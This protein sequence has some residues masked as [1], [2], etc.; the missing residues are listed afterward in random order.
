MA[1]AVQQRAAEAADVAGGV[2]KDARLAAKEQAATGR[3]AGRAGILAKARTAGMAGAQHVAAV[4]KA[5]AVARPAGC[6][7]SGNRHL[8]PARC[9]PLLLMHVF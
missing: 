3:S 1:D 9:L 8:L 4:G 7:T 5:T 2:E 6:M